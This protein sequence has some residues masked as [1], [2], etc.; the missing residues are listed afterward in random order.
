[1]TQPPLPTVLVL[2]TGDSITLLVDWEHHH[3]GNRG[4]A[5]YTSAWS[6]PKAEV[7]SQQRFTC[8]SHAGEVR[9][10]QAHRGYEIATDAAG[11]SSPNPLLMRYQ[12]DG[13]G[14]FAGQGSYGYLSI[15][16]F[17]E[18]VHGQEVDLA[19]IQRTRF[20]TAILEA[21]RQSL[22][23]NGARISLT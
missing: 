9:I 20:V 17:I 1:M 19:T 22:N 2:G 10:D 11:Y 5:V 12:P 18:A 6:A 16:N 23:Q 4:T 7:H 3:S 14:N 13:N 21:G 15:A 8:L